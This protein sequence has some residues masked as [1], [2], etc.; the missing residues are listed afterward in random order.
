MRSHAGISKANRAD[1][2]PRI[3]SS[4]YS[5]GELF[6]CTLNN[7]IGPSKKYENLTT[8]LPYLSCLNPVEPRIRVGFVGDLMRIG[9]A[10]MELSDEVL[11]FFEDVDYIIGNFEGVL[12][13]P[14]RKAKPVFMGQRISHGV[15]DL[16]KQFKDPERIV[17]SCANNHAGDFGLHHFEHTYK[18]LSDEGFQVI[19]SLDRPGIEL[20]GA[21][22]VVA[23]TQWSNQPVSFLSYMNEADGWY[24]PEANAN[25]LV[26]HWGY[27]MQLYPN[28]HQ[29]VTARDLLKR[30][31]MLIGH[32]SHCPQPITSYASGHYQKLV[33]YSLGNFTYRRDRMNYRYG[34]I[35]K[36]ELGPDLY[37]Q[38][39]TGTCQWAYSRVHFLS[40]GRNR[41]AE[42]RISELP[43]WL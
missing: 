28:P 19:G 18:V 26:M 10:N 16:L 14:N 5:P 27:E 12:V 13:D 23:C 22:N 25:I 38:W 11:A 36:A 6:V 20:P 2:K 39:A 41:R 43:R 33:A 31:D 30:W 9:T 32:H 37:G 17:L 7:M 34:S 24:N 8:S 42:I 21:I 29:I 1:G 15:I 4:P 35:L 40:R 3:I